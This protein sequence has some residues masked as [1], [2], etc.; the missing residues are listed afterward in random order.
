[1]A[2]C[3]EKLWNKV[4][5]NCERADLKAMSFPGSL[6]FISNY[7]NIAAQ[8]ET[9]PWHAR[10]AAL[11]FALAQAWNLPCAYERSVKLSP[12]SF[13][14]NRYLLAFEASQ[15]SEAHV[16]FACE[17]L[18]M[19][20]PVM[21][22]IKKRLRRA[23][24]FM[25]GF[26]DAE[27]SVVFKVYLEL[28]RLGRR[29]PRSHV[30][31]KQSLASPASCRS[32][33]TRVAFYK[34]IAVCPLEITDRTLGSETHAMAVLQHVLRA[35]QIAK[36]DLICLLVSE[37]NGRRSF[38]W[39]V[40]AANL[41]VSHFGPAI[42]ALADQYGLERAVVNRWLGLCGHALWDMLPAVLMH[43]ALNF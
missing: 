3:F 38:D 18:S 4:L 6:P 25:L 37:S 2:A 31:W 22:P 24:Q 14:S 40:Y 20:A 23:S 5:R 8:L 41:S 15:I 19:P 33:N 21:A 42:L 13:L 34:P 10:Q 43:K 17:R 11:P 7:E 29:A 30:G 9:Y 26:E 36:G 39:N 27:D 16:E 1:M 12:G 28:R 35:A 32:A